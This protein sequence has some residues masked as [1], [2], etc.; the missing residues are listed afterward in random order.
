MCWTLSRFYDIMFISSEETPASISTDRRIQFAGQPDEEE[1]ILMKVIEIQCPNCGGTV[2]RKADEYFAVCPYCNVEI[3]F[4]DLKEEAAVTGMR[5][6]LETLDRHFKNEKA[7]KN[8]SAKRNKK[9]KLLLA[10]ATLLYLTGAVLTGI[11]DVDSAAM[12]I[13][14]LILLCAF[15]VYLPTTI[16]YAHTY[17][18]FNDDK[19]AAESKRSSK[20][21]MWLRLTGICLLLIFLA[22]IAAALLCLLLA[23]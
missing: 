20:F 21:Y 3:G 8:E 5:S 13:G 6:K 4:D 11:G 16:V 17:S 1:R 19:G 14:V 9:L 15:A 18:V 12:S 7:F 10:A 22:T 23:K 2:S